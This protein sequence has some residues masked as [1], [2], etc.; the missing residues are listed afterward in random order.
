MH[1][2][3]SHNCAQLRA[4]DEGATVRLSGWVHRKR[5]HGGVLF[6]DLR[7]H[8]GL[9]QIVAD[10][11]SPAFATLD[12]VRV[13]SVI[14]ITGNV[15][16][17]A[18]GTTNPNLATGEI[19]VY[20][21][22]ATVQSAAAEL[23]LPVAGE[24][25]YP[26]DIR[27]RYRY[28][29]LRRDR[30]HKNIV[31]RS[32]VIA[33]L[34]RRMI[35]QGFTEFQTPILTASSPEGARDYLVPSRVHPGK[36]Y[37]L[38]Q[39]PQMFKQLLMVAGFDRYFQ[40]APCFRDEDA[41]ADRSP[42]EFYQLDFEMSYVTQEDVF[43]AIEPVL[44]GVFEEFADFEGKGRTVSPLPFRR[45]PYRESMLKY[46]NDKPDL[47]NPILISDVS[48]YFEGSGFGRFASIV[49][50]GDVVRAIPA[51]NT[52]DKSR[53]FFDDMNAWAQSEGFAGLG[54]AT[55]KGGEWGGPIAKNH[56]EEGMNVMADALGLGPDD[57]LFFA[58][59]KEAQAAKLAG[60]A[61]TRVGE[62]LGLIDASR[63]E[64]CWIV[65]F[66][67]FEYD[68]DAKKIDFSHNP[69]SMPQGELEALE[70]KDPLDILAYQYDIVCN[71]VELSSG[72]I[73]N[74]KPEIMYKA[75]EIAGYSREDVDTNFAG[76][77]NA[78]KYGAP[79]HGGSAPG[80]DRIV[81]LLADE[82]NIRE[83]IVFPMTQKA[84]DLMMQAPAPAT[85]KQLRELN[86]RVV[87]PSKG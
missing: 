13:E 54:Y 33:S 80:V 83:V 2:Y 25:E 32:N 11:D 30:L 14:T 56:G 38:P 64:F 18:E 86:I 74:H 17:R 84:E 65:D 8:Y 85:M 49:E 60:L 37:A 55:R 77:I 73:R 6:V 36:F 19:E 44:H 7:D 87:E 69:F 71:G 79:P 29:D 39:A 5:D 67:M 61:R 53:K 59:G 26:E 40:I 10:G 24:A 21:R 72:A 12:A 9:T 63:F 47:R 43:A 52:A 70:T 20:A 46:G 62:Q 42:G 22:E 66:P 31:L 28:L 45:I 48:G 15:K 23:P 76:M 1:A 75:F 41:R 16:L 68:E 81:M 3:R 50:A 4:A 58:A 27:L 78:F 35:D 57:G 34:R 82:P 51:P